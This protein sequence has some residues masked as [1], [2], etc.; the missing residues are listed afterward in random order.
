MTG[1]LQIEVYAADGTDHVRSLHLTA[2]QSEIITAWVKADIDRL[3]EPLEPFELAMLD[4]E[5]LWRLPDAELRELLE[6]S[7]TMVVYGKLCASVSLAGLMIEARF[8]EDLMIDVGAQMLDQQGLDGNAYRALPRKE[9]S[10]FDA[11]QYADET[12]PTEH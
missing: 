8:G 5:E 10:E 1:Q 3:V 2:A 9:R 12:V 11:R 4:G 7:W 6:G